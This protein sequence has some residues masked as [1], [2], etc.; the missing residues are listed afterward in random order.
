M[1]D[2]SDLI[3]DFNALKA[4]VDAIET[5]LANLEPEASKLA[6]EMTTLSGTVSALNTGLSNLQAAAE[7]LVDP[8]T[9]IRANDI[10][11]LRA[12][13]DSNLKVRIISYKGYALD[14][15]YGGCDAGDGA[16][17]VQFQKDN[18]SN[19]ALDMT[20]KIVR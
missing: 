4:R 12:L 18:P 7:A 19:K 6:G 8:A 5:T 9:G 13:T 16:R 3:N 2:L 1:P 15:H 20:L 10:L 17:T 14:N 11:A